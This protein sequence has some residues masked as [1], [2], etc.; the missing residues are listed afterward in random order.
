MMNMSRWLAATSRHTAGQIAQI[1]APRCGLVTSFNPATYR[2]QVQLQPDGQLSG[3][4]PVL[5]QWVGAGWGMVAPLQA[6]DQVLV[7][8]EGNDPAQGVIVGRYYS[9]VDTPPTGEAA[10]EFWLV[11]ETGS[12]I[13]MK[14][15]GSVSIL[16]ATLNIAAPGGGDATVN[17]TGSL[18]VSVETTTAGKAFTPHGHDYLAGTSPSETGPPLG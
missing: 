18:N 15:D 9:D 7:L 1:G 10:G 12:K 3:W 4:L 16:T 17:I 13:A 14:A 2:A 5:S 11:H 6:G 8:P